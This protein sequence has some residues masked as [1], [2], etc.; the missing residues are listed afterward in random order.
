MTAKVR[1]DVSDLT[2][3]EMADA[4]EAAGDPDAAGSNFRQ[5]AAMAWVTM[6]RTEPDYQLKDALELRMGDID[7]VEQPG[8]AQGG[9]PGVTPPA[10]PEPGP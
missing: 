7:I 9:E 2:L 6:R 5:M 10:S 8:E 3:G 4:T 1:V